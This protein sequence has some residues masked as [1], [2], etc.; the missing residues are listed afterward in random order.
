MNSQEIKE[1][2]LII[3]NH[4]IKNGLGDIADDLTQETF[5]RILSNNPNE[6]H[7]TKIA[8]NVLYEQLRAKKSEIRHLKQLFVLY[9][10]A[11]SGVGSVDSLELKETL[12]ALTTAITE[13][14][15]KSRQAVILTCL[16]G[17]KAKEAADLIGCDFKAFRM[18]LGYGLKCLRKKMKKYF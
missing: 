1:N 8:K 9:R 4:L 7:I 6:R 2:E 17:L 15:P 16:E 10:L 13:L 3:K 5:V 14:P 11:V 18:R 12:Q